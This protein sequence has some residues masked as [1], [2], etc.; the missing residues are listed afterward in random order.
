MTTE[1]QKQ[2]PIYSE[3]AYD[4]AFKT[5][6]NEC[7]DLV[8]PFVNHMFGENYGKTAKI[9]RLADEHHTEDLDGSDL[10][11]ITDSRF[12]I[13]FENVIKSY[14]MECESNKYD[15]SI[16]VRIFEYDALIAKEDAQK[17]MDYIR[18]KFPRTGLLLLRASGSAPAKAKIE[19]ELPNG[20]CPS[21]EMPIIKVSDY[22][23]DEIF[24]KNLYMLIPF[25]AFNFESQFDEM[26]GSEEKLETFSEIYSGIFERMKVELDRGN[27]SPMSYSVIIKLIYSVA[28]KLTMKQEN[29]QRKVGEIMGGNVLDLPEIRIY[30]QGKAEGKAEGEITIID[31]NKWL[32]SQGRGNEI[33]RY[34]ENPDYLKTLLAEYNSARS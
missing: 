12:E 29:V 32:F 23:I 22:S 15:G 6:Q 21:Y 34:T 25:Y 19:M 30:K 28:Y 24:D 11:R 31:L 5:M 14:H 26:N 9:R 10:K 8:I 4:D 17:S 20:Q 33:E 16:L 27:L 1:Q 7:D 3:T 18:L 2:N 13:E